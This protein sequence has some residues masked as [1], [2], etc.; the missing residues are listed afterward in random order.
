[1]EERKVIA[2]FKLADYRVIRPLMFLEKDGNTVA[3][4]QQLSSFTINKCEIS[5]ITPNSVTLFYNK[6]WKEYQQAIKIYNEILNPNL[7]D[8]I[9]YDVPADDLPKL[10][11]YLEHVQASIITIYSAI[12]ALCNVAIP[13]KFTLTK[14]NSRGVT[15]LWDK[16]HIERW[17]STE[18][19]IGSIV[20]DILGIES[21][22]KLPLWEHYKNLKD[23]RDDI[24]HQKQSVSNPNEI[25]STFLFI[26][27][28]ENI[29]R[30][31]MAGFELIQYFCEKD[32]THTFF[33]MLSAEVPVNINMVDSF[34]GTFSFTKI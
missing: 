2:P 23:I 6:S 7:N 24:I 28:H 22:K 14:K 9:T 18:E 30:T 29:F 26:L 25:E 33:P 32:K 34:A 31:I 10:Y 20:P 21:P 19:K 11:D 4:V 12:E 27:V 16:S 5:F 13:A 15:E 8:K 3:S 17:I 1:M